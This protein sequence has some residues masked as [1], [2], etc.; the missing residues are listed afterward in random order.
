MRKIKFTSEG[1]NDLRYWQEHDEKKVKRI[2][3]L[4]ANIRDTP[5]KGIGKPEPLRFDY[6]GKWSRRIDQENRLI[7]SVDP[8]TITVYQARYHY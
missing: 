2:K 3:Q 7:Y 6:S 4:L 1:M 5:F 8:D